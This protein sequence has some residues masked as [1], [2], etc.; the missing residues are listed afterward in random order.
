MKQAAEELA[1][2]AELVGSKLYG[3]QEAK[4]REIAKH[5]FDHN[6]FYRQAVGGAF[7]DKWTDLPIL[8]KQ[9]YQQPLP[10]LLADGYRPK[11][12]YVANTSGSTGNPFYFAKDKLAHAL[13]WVSAFEAYRHYGLHGNSLQA[14]FFGIPLSGKSRLIEQIKDFAMNRVRF[15]I[16]DLGSDTLQVY[17]DRF[18]SRKFEYVYGYTNSVRHFAAFLKTKQV[19]LKEVCP[20][21]KAVI[22]TAEMCSR[23]DRE[24]ISQATGVP[25]Y[26]E[27]GASEAGYIAFSNGGDDLQ[28][29]D[30]LLYLETTAER[31]IL[32]TTFYNKAFPLI[33]Y[34]IGDIGT[35]EQTES[36]TILKTL[37]G[38]SDDLVRLP[39]GKEAAG[40]TF[41][42]CTR[43]ILEK[44]AN[45]KEIYFTQKTL[46]R[47]LIN[48]VSDTELSEQDRNVIVTNIDKMLQPGLDLVFERTDTVRRKKNG[49]FQVF[50]S[51][52]EKV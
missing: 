4:C 35:L 17:L 43:A 39:S 7:P 15:P 16:F 24:F 5:H 20:T 2:S 27:Y 34:K 22:V 25:V 45:I 40:L 52:L 47:F 3:W 36:G 48:Y 42:Y 49:K 50:T 21:L 6:A 46:S 32:V 13:T 38:R 18:K 31:E 33:R 11:D 1:A 26:I 37:L 28:V 41:Y 10:Q 23:E 9:H 44:S 14:R 51:E 30:R 12:V 29:L 8:T 19:V